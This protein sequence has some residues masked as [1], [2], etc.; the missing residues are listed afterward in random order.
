MTSQ[1]KGYPFEVII[2]DDP[3]QTS[4]VGGRSNQELGLEDS[5]SREKRDGFVKRGDGNTE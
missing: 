5:P 1:K 4:V 2:S 3:H